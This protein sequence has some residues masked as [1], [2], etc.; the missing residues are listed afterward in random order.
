MANKKNMANSHFTL[1]ASTEKNA[2]GSPKVCNYDIVQSAIYTLTLDVE[3]RDKP[4]ELGKA[5]LINK[6]QPLKGDNTNN[7]RFQSITV[8][9]KLDAY[10]DG[11]N[12]TN[13]ELIDG[14]PALLQA[15][16]QYDSADQIETT[17]G[18]MVDR[19]VFIVPRKVD[20]QGNETREPAM[21]T[22]QYL[23]GAF[24]RNIRLKAQAIMHETNRIEAERVMRQELDLPAP[25][26]KPK[27]T[28]KTKEGSTF[29]PMSLVR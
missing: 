15:I 8:V 26:G 1:T 6:D 22:A 12:L 29:D 5:E 7:Y 13:Q 9:P 28:K 10:L 14:I 19:K 16:E 21:S 3:G 4:V 18:R 17:D 25:A 24:Y 11:G 27:R 20:A 2:D 23:A